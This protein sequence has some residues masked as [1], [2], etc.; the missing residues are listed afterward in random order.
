VGGPDL[1]SEAWVFPA[2]VLYRLQKSQIFEGYGLQPVCNN[3]RIDAAL[4]A[5]GCDFAVTRLFRSL[6]NRNLY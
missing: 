6:F 1:A 5:E 4:A 2:N 3:F